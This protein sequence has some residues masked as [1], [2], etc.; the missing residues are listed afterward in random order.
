M[1]SKNYVIL[2]KNIAIDESMVFLTDR[3]YALMFYMHIN[4][5]NDLKYTQR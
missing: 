3:K 1:N 4:Q 5:Q 2:G